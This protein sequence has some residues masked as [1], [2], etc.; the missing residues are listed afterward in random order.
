MDRDVIERKLDSLH[1]CLQRVRDRTPASVSMLQQDIDAQDVLV[2]N[3]TRAVQV[4]VDLALHALSDQN[5]P[6]PD[7]M[8]EAFDR[9]HQAG[10]INAELATRM[11]QS[12]G[13]RNIAV[14]AYSAIDWQIVFI[15]ATAHLGDFTEFAR[16]THAAMP[17]ETSGKTAQ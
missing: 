14:H 16:L 2:L 8:G 4:C 12:V 17:H 11:K 1:R 6:P 5:L 3:L 7:S 10:M 9:M 15:I 13:F